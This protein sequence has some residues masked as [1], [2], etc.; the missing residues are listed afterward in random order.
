[1]VTGSRWPRYHSGR[2]LLGPL[3]TAPEELHAI[4]CLALSAI[5]SQVVGPCDSTPA[6][7]LPAVMAPAPTL[8]AWPH[9][10]S[11]I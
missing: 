10:G 2:E 5:L 8:I 3:T 6:G 7:V 11:Y 9:L 1:M 4:A